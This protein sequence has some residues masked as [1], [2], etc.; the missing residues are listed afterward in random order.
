MKPEQSGARTPRRAA[1]PRSCLRLHNSAQGPFPQ[2]Q[3]LRNN[4]FKKFLE[5]CMKS[6]KAFEMQR[7]V[8]LVSTK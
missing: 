7:F 8:C 1:L 6:N 4:S 5:V 3:G 2:T